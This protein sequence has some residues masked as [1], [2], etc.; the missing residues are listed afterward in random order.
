M[1]L[2]A[3]RQERKGSAVR[4]KLNEALVDFHRPHPS[5]EALR[6]RVKDT[7]QFLIHA[8]ITPEQSK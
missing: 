1:A 8:G 4:F 3:T 2:G 7:R 6:Y 5:K